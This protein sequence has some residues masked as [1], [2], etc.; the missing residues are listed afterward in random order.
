MHAKLNRQTEIAVGDLV[1]F[2]TKF[3]ALASARISANVIALFGPLLGGAGSLLDGVELDGAGGL[4][5][6]LLEEDIGTFLPA[7]AEA[8]GKL[9]GK[10]LEDMLVE[11]L[12]KEGCISFDGDRLTQA[13]LD[14]VF[15]GDLMGLLTLAYK[16]VELNYGN[17]FTMLGSRFGNREKE[18]APEGKKVLT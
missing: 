14:E 5:T 9:D 16:V 12:V 18:E 17:L 2:V 13:T 1:F 4:D 3:R 6:S 8:A 11:L 7:L 15:C 10:K